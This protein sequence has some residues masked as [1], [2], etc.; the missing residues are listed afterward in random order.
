MKPLLL[1]LLIL[2]AS[3]TAG[4]KVAPVTVW[5][6]D[7][8]ECI[9][10]P[11]SNSKVTLIETGEEFYTDNS[12]FLHFN[13]TV[14]SDITFLLAE[15]SEYH[16]TQTSTVTVPNEGLATELTQVILQVPSH[17]IY[18]LFYL[19]TPG[20]KDD[21]KCSVVVTVCNV[22]RT[23][24]SSPQGL[25]GSVLT[26]TPPDFTSLF[27]FGTWGNWSNTTN[28]F[29]N[30]LNSTSWDGGVLIENLHVNTQVQYLVQAFHPGFNFTSTRIKCLK[31]N[32]FVNAAP[33]QGP[34]AFPT[35]WEVY[36]EWSASSANEREASRYS[37][38]LFLRALEKKRNLLTNISKKNVIEGSGGK[39]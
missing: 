29:P 8:V 26:V 21:T 18:D 13:A 33:N 28:P 12:G 15:T 3:V 5:A 36:A 9:T 1:V 17:F 11:V 14:G 10:K 38:Q 25:P 37:R 24:K 27:Y 30:N 32:T 31:E 6:C 2:F 16:E 7:Y 19:V 23:I 20:K 34:R 4:Q 35:D 39:R 22:N